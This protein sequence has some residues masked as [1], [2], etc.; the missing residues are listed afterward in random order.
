MIRWKVH[1]F[2]HQRTVLFC[3][4]WPENSKRGVEFLCEAAWAFARTFEHGAFDRERKRGDT[5]P[6]VCVCVWCVCFL[7]MAW[8]KKYDKKRRA[9]VLHERESR[10]GI[11]ICVRN[12]DL[13]VWQNASAVSVGLWGVRQLAPRASDAHTHNRKAFAF[14]KAHRRDL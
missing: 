3:L 8:R 6:G 2:L 5:W 7:T 11:N 1:Q 14:L 10:L 12:S 9:A 13:S 4:Q